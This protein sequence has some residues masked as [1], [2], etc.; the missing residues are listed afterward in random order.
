MV[1]ENINL[2]FDTL[3]K[4]ASTSDDFGGDNLSLKELA[5]IR[6]NVEDGEHSRQ[7]KTFVI[8]RLVRII[9]VGGI[10][11][12]LLLFFQGTHHVPGLSYNFSLDEWALKFFVIGYLGATYGLLRYVVQYYFPV[13]QKGFFEKL[14]DSLFGK[15]TSANSTD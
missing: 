4:K 5:D 12:F 8:Q 13:S 14:L 6:N 1:K 2:I 7:Q 11:L 3:A 10:A 15:K 9:G